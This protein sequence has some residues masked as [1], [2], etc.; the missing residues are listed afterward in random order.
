MKL[1]RVLAETNWVDSPHPDKEWTGGF[2]KKD[3]YHDA[4]HAHRGAD[5]GV[6]TMNQVVYGN[7]P[8]SMGL[9][10]SATLTR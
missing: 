7:P 10:F 3:R 2:M 5:G 1:T 6:A 9:G 4:I 8:L